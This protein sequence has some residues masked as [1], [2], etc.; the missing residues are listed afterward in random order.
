MKSAFIRFWSFRVRVL[1]L[2]F[3]FMVYG[4]WFMIYGLWSMVYDLWFWAYDLGLTVW[5]LGCR[6]PRIHRTGVTRS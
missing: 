3:G 6:V 4:L 2:E 5:G 1:E